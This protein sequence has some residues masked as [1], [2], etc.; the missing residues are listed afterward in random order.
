VNAHTYVHI[1][2]KSVERKSRKALHYNGPDRAEEAETVWTHLQ[3]GR[4]TTGEDH[5]LRIRILRILKI[6]E[7]HEF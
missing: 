4:L 2:Q 7:I 5:R 6:P 3:N 1:A